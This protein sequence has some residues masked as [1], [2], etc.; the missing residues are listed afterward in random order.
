MTTSTSP[1]LR[2]RLQLAL[3]NSRHKQKSLHQK[4]FTLVELMI[5][6]VIVGVLSAVALP[7]FLN[8]TS[9]ARG[10]E[11]TTK[12]TGILKQVAAEALMNEGDAN[13]LGA[14]LATTESDNSTYCDITYTDIVDDVAVVDAVGKNELEG[15]CDGNF[16]V[17]ITTGKSDI[18]TAEAEANPVDCATAAPAGGAV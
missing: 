8:Q 11:C 6:I 4:G 14:S 16:C 18:K 12:A 5:V 13:T 1:A 2:S 9:K 3:L 15:K 10:T 17:N 7:N